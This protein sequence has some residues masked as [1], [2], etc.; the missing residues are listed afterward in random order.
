MLILIP[1]R[2]ATGHMLPKDCT[3][4]EV[5]VSGAGRKRMSPN[6]NCQL[7]GLSYIIH[8]LFTQLERPEPKP[9]TKWPEPL[10]R[11]PHTWMNT[12]LA[13][14]WELTSN[15]CSATNSLSNH[16]HW[17][18]LSELQPSS[19]WWSSW[20]R[21]EDTGSVW[22]PGLPCLS[23]SQFPCLSNTSNFTY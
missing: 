19:M 17:L 5:Q 9:W 20:G 21:S 22:G 11:L 1:P 4:T 8:L 23:L 13:D 18:F 14:K 3:L 12:N 10:L 6:A 7:H 16:G 2:D 15:L